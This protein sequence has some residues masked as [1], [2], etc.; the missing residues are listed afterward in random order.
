[1]IVARRDGVESAH[2]NKEIA[3]NRFARLLSIVL[4]ALLAAVVFSAPA[5][6]QVKLLFHNVVDGQVGFWYVGRMASW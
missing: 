2:L 5:N 3:M 6:A 1:M 4:K